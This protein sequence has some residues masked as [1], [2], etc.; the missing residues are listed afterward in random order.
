M[1]Q[2]S[3]LILW[4][5]LSNKWKQGNNVRLP[6]RGTFKRNTRDNC[7][8]CFF[9]CLRIVLTCN[10]FSKIT[11]RPHWSRRES[12]NWDFFIAFPTNLSFL[13]TAVVKGVTTSTAVATFLFVHLAI[14]LY[15]GGFWFWIFN[16]N[17]LHWASHVH[18]RK[19]LSLSRTTATATEKFNRSALWKK[20]DKLKGLNELL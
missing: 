5:F 20:R 15:R 11:A 18:F 4:S 7:S 16:P 14:G 9:F 13:E 2:N 6:W 17:A 1:S 8:K 3:P 10:I 12:K 19:N